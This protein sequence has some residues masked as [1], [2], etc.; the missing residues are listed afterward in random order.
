MKTNFL[1]IISLD[2][3]RLAYKFQGDTVSWPNLLWLSRKRSV[4]ALLYIR[5]I[6]QGNSLISLFTRLRLRFVYSIEISPGTEIGGGLLLPHPQNIIVSSGVR[7]GEGITISQGAK[8]GGNYKVS[9]SEDSVNTYLPRI[10]NNVWIGPNSVVGGPVRIGDL[11]L[12]GANSE[13]T[14]DIP[15]NSMVVG[16]NKLIKRNIVVD[17]INNTWS[18]I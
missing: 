15:S 16:R 6:L 18:E 7:L 4:C 10:G 13:V 12:I 17:N 9:R 2:L 1:S 14:K 11:V 5:C 3:G 8:V